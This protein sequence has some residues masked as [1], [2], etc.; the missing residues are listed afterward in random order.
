MPS[1]APP[2]NIDR[3]RILLLDQDEYS[4]G[5]LFDDLTER[6]YQNIKRVAT[7][8]LLAASLRELDPVVAIFNFHFQ[9]QSSLDD[10]KAI[11]SLAPDTAVLAIVSAGPA[12]K[13]VRNWA[14]ETQAIDVVIEKPLSDES[15]FLVLRDLVKSRLASRE[16]HARAKGME[17]LLPSGAISAL[18][19]RRGEDAEMFQAAVLFTDI[20]R[21]TQ[22]IT[23]FSPQ[24]FFTILNRALSAQSAHITSFEGVVIK[25][26]GDGVFAVFRGMGRT[27]LALRCAIELAKSESQQ[28]LPFGIGVAEGLVLAGLIGD[29]NKAGLRRQYDVIGATVNLSARLCSLAEPGEVMTTKQVHRAARVSAFRARDVGT[30]DIRGFEHGVECVA[31]DAQ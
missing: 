30:I 13:M 26:T 28:I 17:S 19:R 12:I 6:G 16:L 27:Y 1:N 25:Y 23:Q 14:K 29:S 9:Q 31:H 5:V 24:D 7:S 21:S 2:P 11:K 10:C 22:A 3:A 18:E 8:D 20:R 15:F 4:A